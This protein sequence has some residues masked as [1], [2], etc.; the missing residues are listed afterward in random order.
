M[1]PPRKKPAR[2]GI[3][4]APERSFPRHQKFVRGH[5]CCIAGT[6]HICRGPIVF[7]HVRTGTDG[8]TGL[9]SNDVW[10]ISLC[11]D[12]HEE[13]HRIGEPAFERKYRID[14][15][16]LAREFAARTTDTAMRIAMKEA[17]L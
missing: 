13:Q 9:K 15:K 17:G 14:M 11:A 4:R 1:L 5:C 2:S 8:G 10:G 12:A 7:A 3:R 6:G 16:A